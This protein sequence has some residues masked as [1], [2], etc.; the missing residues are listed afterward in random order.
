MSR[1]PGI[2]FQLFTM[3]MKRA[4]KHMNRLSPQRGRFVSALVVDKT[5]HRDHGKVLGSRH[6]IVEGNAVFSERTSKEGQDGA[7]ANAPQSPPGV[8]DPDHAIA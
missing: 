3:F 4:A 6:A 8:I 1:H 2:D 7:S 5:I